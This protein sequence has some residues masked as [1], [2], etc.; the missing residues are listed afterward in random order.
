M[1]KK[2]D[3]IYHAASQ[4]DQQRLADNINNVHDAR[5]RVVKDGQLHI[6]KSDT[7]NGIPL[8]TLHNRLNKVLR[9]A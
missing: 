2:V 1:S 7:L 5:A 8:S 3:Y 4:A 6:I 9:A